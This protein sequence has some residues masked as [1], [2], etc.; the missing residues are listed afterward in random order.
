M[1][2]EAVFDG[3]ALRHRGVAEGR[4]KNNMSWA[5]PGQLTINVMHELLQWFL[6]RPSL[7][8][9]DRLETLGHSQS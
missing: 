5:D 9:F 3:I 8:W 7:H 4:L 6:D 2:D 1:L